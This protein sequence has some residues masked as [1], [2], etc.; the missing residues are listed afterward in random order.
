[1]A[2][3]TLHFAAFILDLLQTH[4]VLTLATVR[5]DGWPQATSVGYVN[6]G[7]T[8]YVATGA[9]AQKALN[10]RHNEKVSVAIDRGRGGRIDW[11]SLQGCRWRRSPRS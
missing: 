1:M 8:L 6:E 10:I 3:W 11:K 5:E 2:T 7:L 4:E 9:Y